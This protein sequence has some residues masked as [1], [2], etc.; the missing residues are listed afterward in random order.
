MPTERFPFQQACVREALGDDGPIVNVGCLDDQRDFPG[1]SIKLIAPDR[2]INTDLAPVHDVF[3]ERDGEPVKTGMVATAADVFFDAAR[4]R[5]P[6]EDRVAALVILGDILE[7]M[8]EDDIRATL[9]EARRVGRRLC[10][11]S[12]EDHRDSNSPEHASHYPRGHHQ[13]HQ[14]IVTEELLRDLLVQ[15]G[16]EV[17]GWQ[18]VEYDDGRHWGVR[19]MGHWVEAS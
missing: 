1:N 9:T 14:T 4:D 8:S 3:E 10:V 5:W 15:S 7:H 12:P 2:I 11:T 16:W 18:L 6:F 13:A 19:T 17:T